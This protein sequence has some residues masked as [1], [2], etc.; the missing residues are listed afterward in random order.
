MLLEAV[1]YFPYMTKILKEKS[2]LTKKQMNELL[3]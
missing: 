2:T 3:K 1:A